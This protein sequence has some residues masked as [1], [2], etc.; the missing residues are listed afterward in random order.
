MLDEGLYEV[1]LKYSSKQYHNLHL[2][3][4]KNEFFPS[5][6]TFDLSFSNQI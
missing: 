5:A 6:T 3:E 2:F 1:W 4:K